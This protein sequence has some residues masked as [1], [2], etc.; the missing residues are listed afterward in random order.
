MALHL[1]VMTISGRASAPAVGTWPWIRERKPYCL[2]FSVF[3]DGK[4]PLWRF[5][6]EMVTRFGVGRAAWKDIACV[7]A[8]AY[9]EGAEVESNGARESGQTLT[10]LRN[11]M[12]RNPRA[13]IKPGHGLH[14][15]R[16]APA[17]SRIT[18]LRK[19]KK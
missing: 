10:L 4:L 11:N 7:Q 9:C 3:A 15:S 18:D 8:G 13:G 12:T 6:R 16:S 17:D 5:E 14:H 19:G 2:S 1:K